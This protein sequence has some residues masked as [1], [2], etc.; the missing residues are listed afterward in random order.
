[1]RL[2]TPWFE[3]KGLEAPQVAPRLLGNFVNCRTCLYSAVSEQRDDF[4][5]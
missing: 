3:A 4:V 5:Q 2:G 1:M